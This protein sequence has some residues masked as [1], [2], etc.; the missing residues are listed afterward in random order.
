MKI[1]IAITE[2]N[3]PDV[4]RLNYEYIKKFQPP[5]SKI[6]VVDDASDKPLEEA[7]YR[8]ENRVGIA[9][10]KNKCLEFC[11][12]WGA[13]HIFLFDSD[14]RPKATNWWQPY[15]NHK[16][17]HLMYVF[18]SYGGQT[19]VVKELYRDEQTVEFNHV[20]GCMLYYD[21][22]CI[23]K[24]GGFDPV[25]SYGYFEHRNLTERIHKAGLTSR[26]IMDVP[27]SGGLIHSMDEWKEVD[28]TFTA[29][30]HGKLLRRNRLLNRHKKKLYVPYN[31]GSNTVL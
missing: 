22:I 30:E 10:A 26:L 9:V 4:F 8:F 17:P 20:R 31:S 3:R 13:D 23:E 24:C 25:F 16:E 29:E 19:R 21:R 2:R 11:M 14:T 27:D 15:V 18:T 5:N 28:S 7:D 12:K 1:G 6:F